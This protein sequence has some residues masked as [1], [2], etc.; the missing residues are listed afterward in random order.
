MP[1]YIMLAAIQRSGAWSLKKNK[2]MTP[3]ATLSHSLWQSLKTN[4]LIAI[5]IS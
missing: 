1:Q 3:Q 4:N 2:K 5:G